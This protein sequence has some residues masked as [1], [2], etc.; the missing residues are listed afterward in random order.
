[1]LVLLY[2][3]KFAWIL[4][5]LIHNFKDFLQIPLTF[6]K[7]MLHFWHKLRTSPSKVGVVYDLSTGWDRMECQNFGSLWKVFEL[8][9]CRRSRRKRRLRRNYFMGTIQRFVGNICKNSVYTDWNM[10]I[11]SWR[12]ICAHFD[13]TH[14]AHFTA[15]WKI[16]I[17]C[18]MCAYQ[19][20]IMTF[21][22]LKQFNLS[23]FDSSYSNL[24]WRSN[25]LIKFS[26]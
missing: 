4:K 3:S 9:L 12:I 6:P 25:Q 21:G 20:I 19:E 23:H 5:I 1:M 8:L 26:S 2:S 10:C 11:V 13:I 14:Q 22:F 16:R 17:S 15:S 24:L 7:K 18:H